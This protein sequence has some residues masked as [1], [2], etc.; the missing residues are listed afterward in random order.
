MIGD[1]FDDEA[2][3]GDAFA[4]DSWLILATYGA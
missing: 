2:L 3:V 4:G 1:L